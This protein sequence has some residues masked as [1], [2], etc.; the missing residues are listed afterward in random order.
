M[1]VTSSLRR[2]LFHCP[3]TIEPKF[4]AFDT[5]LLSAM[6]HCLFLSF[7][8]RSLLLPHDYSLNSHLLPKITVLLRMSLHLPQILLNESERTRIRSF[9]R[10][11]FVFDC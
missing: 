1:Y 8:I 3:N 10:S 11:R 6:H 5:L 2:R 7:Q 9:T 4:N